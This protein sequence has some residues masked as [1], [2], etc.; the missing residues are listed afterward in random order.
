MGSEVA[1]AH[2]Q[3][4]GQGKDALELW[5]GTMTQRDATWGHP[6]VSREDSGRQEQK[7]GLSLFFPVPRGRALHRHL[8]RPQAPIS[9]FVPTKNLVRRWRARSVVS[10]FAQEGDGGSQSLLGFFRLK[11]NCVFGEKIKETRWFFE[12]LRTYK[13]PDTLSDKR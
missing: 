10:V 3:L 5:P 12:E 9:E 13:L 6:G 4:R 7:V 11:I 1:Q 2:S 8:Q